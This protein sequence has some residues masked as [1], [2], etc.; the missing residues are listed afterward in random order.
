MMIM[1]YLIHFIIVFNHSFFLIKIHKWMTSDFLKRGATPSCQMYSYICNELYSLTHNKYILIK[2]SSY[3]YSGKWFLTCYFLKID[4]SNYFVSI[5]WAPTN[6][7]RNQTKQ[8]SYIPNSKG[9]TDH[10]WQ[11]GTSPLYL[12]YIMSSWF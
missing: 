8:C 5:T 1:S 4:T 6:K 9:P 12:S 3:S 10:S 2:L 7:A 11:P